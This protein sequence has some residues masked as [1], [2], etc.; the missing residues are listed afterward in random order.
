[1]YTEQVPTVMPFQSN[2]DLAEEL[3][4]PD[5][6]KPTVEEVEV[7]FYIIFKFLL[8]WVYLQGGLT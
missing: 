3:K 6:L 8:L 7:R 4:E 1:M 5:T 2:D